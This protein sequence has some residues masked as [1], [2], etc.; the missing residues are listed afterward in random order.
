MFPLHEVKSFKLIIEPQRV[1]AYRRPQSIVFK[2]TGDNL[3]SILQSDNVF[4][5]LVYV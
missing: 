2:S 3:L 5:L 4:N 1:E